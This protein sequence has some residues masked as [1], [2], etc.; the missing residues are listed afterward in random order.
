MVHEC[1]NAAQVNGINRRA[2]SLLTDYAECHKSFSREPLR[3]AKLLF[4]VL[5]MVLTG[6]AAEAQITNIQI[7]VK[8]PAVVSIKAE[9][10]APIGH[11][12]FRNTYAGIL[13]L[14]E[15]IELQQARAGASQVT[16]KRIAPGEYQAESPFSQFQYDVHFEDT[17]PAGQM[18]HVSWLKAEDGALMLADLWPTNAPRTLR[19]SIELPAGWNIA[20]NATRDGSSFTIDDPDSTVFVLGKSIRVSTTNNLTI[21]TSGDFPFKEAEAAK[22]ISRI[23]VSYR[24][25]TG[26]ELR[27]QPFVIVIPYPGD[28]SPDKWTAETRGNVVV[29]VMGRNGQAKQ[30][31]Y[32]LAFILSHELF[33]FWIP[34][35]LELEGD[36]DWFFEGFT[37]YRALRTDLDL[38][39]INFQEFLNTL[40]RAFRSY[41]VDGARDRLS[42]IEA[43]E[44]RWTTPPSLIYNKGMLVAFLYDL[45]VRKV[46]GCEASLDNVYRQ[47]FAAPR[48]GQGS[49]NEIII[50]ALGSRAE[51]HAFIQNYVEQPAA[52]DLQPMLDEFGL[53]GQVASN[54]PSIIKVKHP[55]PSQK[56]LLH[57]L[58]SN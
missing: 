43:S 37:V 6:S 58:Q 15:R 36:Y 8:S 50:R 19:A 12:S 13:G 56:K 39:L 27:R 46:S 17:I 16:V 35:A 9:L 5:V 55:N 24:G 26:Y 21:A 30:T 57:C 1:V 28:T 11:L 42:L 14:G 33:H 2:F 51:L 44:R 20:S 25:L 52:V 10:P 23:L 38:K 32:Q 31:L 3:R 47:L 49:A 7:V 48:T 18:S 34:N 41:S 29:L 22:L 54:R 45:T 40:A 4:A 53:D